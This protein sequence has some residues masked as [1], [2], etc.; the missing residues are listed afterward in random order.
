M[1]ATPREA[2]PRRTRRHD[3]NRRDRIVDAALEVIARDGAAAATHRAVA[4]AADVPLGSTTYHFASRDDLLAEAFTRHGAAVAAR[5]DARLREATGRADVVAAL[6]AHV[7]EDLLGSPRDLVLT[8]E[9]YAAAARNPAL[10]SITQ[11]WMERSREV[12][13]RH[14]DPGSARGLDALVEGLVL[15]SALS[16][17]P[18]SPDDVRAALGCFAR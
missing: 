9:L 14:L 3:P 17:D 11:A 6:T 2:T 1:T 8:V 13:G 15:H 5:L 10:R 4:R 7:C 18:M 12:L 16:T